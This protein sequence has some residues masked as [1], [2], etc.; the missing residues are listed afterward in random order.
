MS[1][2]M[3]KERG[4]SML[5]VLV[6]M[7]VIMVGALGIAGMQ[8]LAITSTENARYQNVATILTGSL[9]AAMQA[10]VAYWGTPPTKVSV[11]GTTITGGPAATAKICVG[12]TVVC[13]KTEMASYDLK[14][15][16]DEL[17]VLPGSSAVI[18]C[19][20]NKSPAIC[21]IT[22]TWSEK[23]VSLRN[24]DKTE[25]GDLASEQSQPHTYQTLVTIL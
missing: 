23:N 21:S 14:T 8:L 2:N 10:N 11:T 5:E 15:W 4:F 19:P 24:A 22:L 25:T 20:A 13:D 6:A 1:N 7:V 9:S 12:L 17:A 3:N 16:V 18:V